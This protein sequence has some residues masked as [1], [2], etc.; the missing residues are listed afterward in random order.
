MKRS[1]RKASK[2]LAGNAPELGQAAEVIDLFVGELQIE[3][4]IDGLRQA[5]G[6]N[7]VAIARQMA[8]KQLKSGGFA[9]LAGF[10]VT[11]RHGELVEVGEE[12]CHS[13]LFY[14]PLTN[15]AAWSRAPGRVRL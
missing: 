4:I 9:G 1:W 8:E 11:G 7:V 10:E 13:L 15:R 12:A 3:E 5:G 2:K 14:Q 6:Y